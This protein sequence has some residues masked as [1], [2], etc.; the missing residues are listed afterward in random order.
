MVFDYPETFCISMITVA[1]TLLAPEFEI[2]VIETL[3]VPIDILLCSIPDRDSCSVCGYE[4]SK[5][6][7]AS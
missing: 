7:V 5:F 3:N 4:K 6:T 2:P 1:E